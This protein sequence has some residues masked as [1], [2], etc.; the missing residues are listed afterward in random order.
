MSNFARY[1]VGAVVAAIVL[2]LVWYF[3]NIVAYI[4][5]SAVLAIIGKPLVDALLRLRIRG[6]A[7][8]RWLAAFLTL[9]TIW[10][11]AVLFVTFF[12]PLVFS[13]FSELSRL[14]SS[15]VVDAFQGPLQALQ[16]FLSKYFA[17]DASE[18]SLTSELSG[19]LTPLLN[20]DTINKALSSTLALVA[21]TVIALF[22]ITFITFF[23]LKQD[24]LFRNML[25]AMF[26][27]KYEDNIDRALAAV[28]N[29]LIRYFTG[30][31]AES[32][33]VMLLLSCSLLIWGIPADTAFFM[34]FIVGVLN[35]IPYIGPIMGGAICIV[36]GMVSPLISIGVGT[37]VLIIIGNVLFVQ[38]IDNFVLQ[39]IL[40]S[41][42]VKAHPLEIFLVIL[43]AGS[44]AG[45]LGM[46]LAIPSYTVMRVF[47]KEF[48]Y[49]FR[50]VQK[51]TENI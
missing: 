30:I 5:I 4:L 17:F 46:L 34:G 7:I 44:V 35:V 27:K 23:F 20:L 47:A 48:F 8:P 37:M 2:F 29:L 41:N 21:G 28:T 13:K 45:V 11:V 36:V 19:H 33:T 14:D 32:T 15:F 18:F 10:T 12:V 50:I 42:R 24:N 3:S 31:L 25:I 26:P 16:D 38:C 1:V 6:R 9:L 43:I 39:P 40:Y 49:N 22:S 51:L